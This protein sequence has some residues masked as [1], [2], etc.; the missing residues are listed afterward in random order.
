MPFRK[1]IAAL[2]LVS[3]WLFLGYLVWRGNPPTNAFMIALGVSVIA[4]FIWG[5]VPT[6]D[7]DA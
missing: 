6:D 4:G 3:A 5:S 7:E 1:V 2:L